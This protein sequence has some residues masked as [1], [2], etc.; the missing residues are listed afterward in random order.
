MAETGFDTLVKKKADTSDTLALIVRTINDFYTSRFV[1]EA[2][3]ELCPSGTSRDECLHNVFNAAHR[4][5]SYVLDTPGREDVWTPA[6]TILHGKGD[7]KKITVFIASVLKA[8]GIEP[9]L[10]HVYYDDNDMYTHIYVIVADPDINHYITLDAADNTQFNR[11]VSYKGGTLYFLDGRTMELHQMGKG[12]FSS[13][14]FSENF[15]TGCHQMQGDLES[16]G[17][18]FGFDNMGAAGFDIKKLLTATH[19]TTLQAHLNSG[20]NPHQAIMHTLLPNKPKLVH[21]LRNI[22]INK[23]RG[24][25]L[26][27]IEH[28][29]DGL[30]S[31]LARALGAK[32]D[33]LNDVWKVVGGDIAHLKETVLK[34]AQ[35]PPVPMEV[36][37]RVAGPEYISGFFKSLFH[38]A[39]GVL[40]V[41]GAAVSVI[42]GIGSVV[43]PVISKV[44]DAAENIAQKHGDDIDQAA[45]AILPADKKGMNIPDPT[46]AAYSTTS[47]HQGNAAGS[48]GGFIFKSVFIISILNINPTLKAIMSD[49]AIVAP[50]I[51]AWCYKKFC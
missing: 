14:D 42:P 22:P 30:A 13:S 38:A 6:L 49:V 44:G 28:N 5:I 50:L 47:H 18:S 34:G 7:C 21:A 16:I 46:A 43:G 29:I 11:E 39:A 25:F 20:K 24:S 40:H 27:L 23:Q 4:N 8:A 31:N 33:A 37:D 36:A 45:Q 26:T 10:K 35:K 3:A 32:P 17:N 9:V 1:T 48:V 19:G 15:A 12:N 51:F 41:V 2:A